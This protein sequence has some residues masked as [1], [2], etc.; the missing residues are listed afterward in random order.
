MIS[1][2]FAHSFAQYNKWQNSVV[3][4]AA[5]QLSEHQR[6]KNMGAFFG[7]IQGTLSHIL[8]G[9]DAWLN[10]LTQ[11]PF[12]PTPI[13]ESGSLWTD[14]EAYKLARKSLDERI[15]KWAISLED[16][17]FKN[18]L[19]YVNSK[20]VQVTKPIDLIVAHIFNHQTH[21]RGQVHCLL[22]QFGVKTKDTDFLI[23]REN[24]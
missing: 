5:D 9:D 2:D 18:E 23:F 15:V 19:T 6:Q 10:R 1:A 17:F 21:H 7:S 13:D 3:I 22:T 4:E 12:K 8:W 16:S 11:T 24:C 14:W 20:G